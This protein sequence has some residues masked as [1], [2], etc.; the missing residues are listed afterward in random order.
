M[1]QK[2]AKT[3]RKKDDKKLKF[4]IYIKNNEAK[5]NPKK[6]VFFLNIAYYVVCGW[7]FPL[8]KYLFFIIF[9]MNSNHK[10]HHSHTYVS[11]SVPR[12]IKRLEIKIN[13]KF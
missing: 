7:I 12:T 8:L 5:R 2:I 10:C 9:L 6:H 4:K 3:K 11:Q 1:Q 13:K